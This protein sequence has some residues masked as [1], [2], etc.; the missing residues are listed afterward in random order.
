MLNQ[1]NK[2]S[3]IGSFWFGFA[4]G[5]GA[6]SAAAFLLGT[7]KGRILLKNALEIS[8]NLEENLILLGEELEETLVEKGSHIREE[9]RDL[10]KAVANEVTHLKKEHSS[11]GGLLQ[12]IK[13]LSPRP[14]K[15]FFARDGK[16]VNR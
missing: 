15:K 9:L 5:V 10:P 13:T 12:K 8:E 6:T 7:K 4:L 16:F 11:L 2:A 14:V 3:G 1:N